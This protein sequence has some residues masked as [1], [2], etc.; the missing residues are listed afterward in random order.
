[1]S[2]EGQ[3]LKLCRKILTE[4]EYIGDRTGT[5]TY[6]IFGG[7]IRHDL[8][9][10]F[11]L[12][13]TKKVNFE[14]IAGELL[15]FLSGKVDLSS[16]R[17]YQGK[18]ENSHTIWSDDFEKYWDSLDERGI[19]RLA[20]RSNQSGGRLY[21]KQWREYYSCGKDG[22][23][24]KFDQI[25]TLIENIKEVKNGNLRQARRLI[26]TA[27]NP[28][29]HTEG[30]KEVA[31]LSACHDSFQCIVRGNKLNLRFHCRSN[32]MFL[33]NPYNV[34][35]YA[36]LCH[37]LAKLTDLEVGELVYMGTDIHLYSN[38][39]EQVELQLSREPHESPKLILPEFNNL[40]DV[41]KLSGGD[42]ELDG[43]NPHPFIKAPQAS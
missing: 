6:S 21:S 10:G 16:L 15:W 18:P 9:K 26:V 14:L 33:G 19:D 5:G 40:E 29:D 37:I 7:M 22:F 32:D 27:W 28:Y 39:V 23:P 42:F 34:A 17:K 43:Y 2:Y 4:G 25:T 12:L 1:M 41:L 38:H 30:E 8:S 31:A 36:L 35:S 24:F 11:P 13:T 3:Y 20:Q